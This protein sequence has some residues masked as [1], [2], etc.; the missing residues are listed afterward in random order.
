MLIV[1]GNNQ[2]YKIRCVT[3]E[4]FLKG[5]QDVV[6][7]VRLYS[8]VAQVVHFR[9]ML[10][11]ALALIHSF[12]NCLVR[13]IVLINPHLWTLHRCPRI[14]VYFQGECLCLIGSM[15]IVALPPKQQLLFFSLSTATPSQEKL[16]TNR[17]SSCVV[18]TMCE[19]IRA[20]ESLIVA[21]FFIQI[22][23]C[24][25]STSSLSETGDALLLL[26]YYQMIECPCNC[27]CFCNSGFLLPA[28]AS[29]W[30]SSSIPAHV[31]ATSQCSPLT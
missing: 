27:R 24:A 5:R 20:V 19:L 13:C 8:A 21:S 9:L 23:Q 31:R 14:G 30:I 26:R 16:P 2:E 18:D 15:N 6:I 1:M 3:D 12:M 10:S 28:T 4:Y 29:F 11:P 17:F 22:C 25:Q 7:P